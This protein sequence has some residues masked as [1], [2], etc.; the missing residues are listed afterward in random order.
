MHDN[1]TLH[2]LV[3]VLSLL[4]NLRWD[5]FSHPAYFPPSPCP[6]FVCFLY[7]T[8]HEAVAIMQLLK[9]WE[10]ELLVS[11]DNLHIPKQ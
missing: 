10:E 8:G 2:K 3:I 11:I 7:Y 6:I 4:K 1:A 9:K 5:L